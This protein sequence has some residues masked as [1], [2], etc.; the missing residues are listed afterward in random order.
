MG[1]IDKAHYILAGRTLLDYVTAALAPVVDRLIL[2]TN[3]PELHFDFPG[4]VVTDRHRSCGPL[5]GIEAGLIA[6]GE[7]LHF[8]T[9]CDMPFLNSELISYLGQQGRN[10]DIVVPR[11]GHYVEPLHSFYRYNVL[12]QIKSQLKKANYKL[13]ALFT[14]PLQVL[15][16]NEN[17]IKKHDPDLISFFNINTP[18]DVQKAAKMLAHRGGQKW[19]QQQL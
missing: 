17:E 13:S 5:C 19:N 15:H 12:L 11:L 3:N 6:A 1:V 18:A 14:A 9:G 4:E 2:V 10:Y 8:V 7:G 16:V